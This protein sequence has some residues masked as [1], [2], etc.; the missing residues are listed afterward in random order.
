MLPNDG[1]YTL[2]IRVMDQV[3]N[4]NV[5]VTGTTVIV[6][7]TPPAPATSVVAFDTPADSGGSVTVNWVLSSDDGANAND[8]ASYAIERQSGSSGFTEVGSVSAGTN[9][10]VDS[11]A[12]TGTSY[13]YRVTAVD[14]ASNRIASTVSA[15]IAAIDNAGTSDTTP[16]EEV[17]NLT[18]TA[19]S[20]F[21]YLTW[22]RSVDSAGDL[23]DQLLDISADGGATWGT[24]GPAYTDGST[25]SLGKAANTYLVSGLVNSTGYKFRLR[26]QDAAAPANTSAG[27]Q[28]NVVAPSVSAYTTVS[29]TI[30]QDTEWAAGVYYVSN[31]VTVNNGVTLTIRPGVVVK[32]AASRT[33]DVRGTL[34]AQGTSGNEVVF[35]AFTDDSVG[36]DTNGDGPSSGTPGYWGHVQLYDSGSSASRLDHAVVRYGGSSGLGNLYIYRNAAQIRHTQS[37][38]SLYYGIYVGQGAGAGVGRQHVC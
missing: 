3:G 15:A 28:T 27:V 14:L 18:A 8:V 36:G 24:V 13:V 11:T 1:A 10:F 20:G 33:L 29:G 12:V 17:T 4:V 34:L 26:V 16:P 35:T 7:Q 19:G 30:A 22:T 38:D 31:N 37:R 23:I 6:N 32:F 25:L 2:Y 9:S 5:S 21:V